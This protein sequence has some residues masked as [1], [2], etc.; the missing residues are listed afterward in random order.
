MRK[1]LSLALTIGLLPLVIALATMARAEEP[2]GCDKFKWPILREQAALAA[3]EGK[4][5]A[6]DGVVAAGA[7]IVVPLRDVD[8]TS[9]VQPPQRA[10]TE[11]TYGAVLKL[12]APSAGIY[13][14][15]L[16]AGAW[17]D[18][19]QDGAALKPLAFSGAQDCP[20]IRKSLKFQLAPQEATIQISNVHISNGATPEISL[21]VLPE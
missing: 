7:A 13:T 21:V 16:S 15:S 12:A 9:F 3:A 4:N 11:K 10:P 2:V 18:V 8:K 17:I 19:I 6:A 20:H 1:K 14:L 5:A